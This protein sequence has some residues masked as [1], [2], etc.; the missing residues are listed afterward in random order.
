MLFSFFI[1]IITCCDLSQALILFEEKNNIQV[2]ERTWKVVVDINY[3]SVQ[4]DLISISNFFAKFNTTLAIF[5]TELEFTN[6]KA[7]FM[8]KQLVEEYTITYENYL[9]YKNE[10]INFKNLIP[11]YRQKRGLINIGG[12]ILN[13]LFGVMDDDDRLDVENKIADLTDKTSQLITDNKRELT[14]VRNINDLTKNNT[15]NINKII[16]H[17]ASYDQVLQLALGK[18]FSNINSTVTEIENYIQIT[19]VLKNLASNIEQA[20]RKITRLRA[21]LSMLFIGQVT[22]DLI[23]EDQFYKILLEVDRNINNTYKLPFAVHFNQI[24]N[25]YSIVK[26]H[27]IVRDNKIFVILEIPMI[28]NTN[29]NFKLMEVNSLP[30]YHPELDHFIAE[31]LDYKYIAVDNNTLRYFYITMYELQTCLSI[32]NGNLICPEKTIFHN[33]TD[34]GDC[35]FRSF[36]SKTAAENCKTKILTNTQ[37]VFLLSNNNDVYF[38]TSNRRIAISV[39][40]TTWSH[41]E[42]KSTNYSVV[43]ERVG[44]LNSVNGCKI[45]TPQFEYE[46]EG[47]FESK[48]KVLIP[49]VALVDSDIHLKLINSS[50]ILQLNETLSLQPDLIKNTNDIEIDELMENYK[51]LQQKS[52]A[53]TRQLITNVGFITCIA[54]VGIVLFLI[55]LHLHNKLKLA[56]LTS[57]LQKVSGTK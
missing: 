20:T 4:A 32:S 26:D 6:K 55:I 15:D 14:I 17:M 23:P 51:D 50:T 9:S 21:G 33:F 5:K 13:K 45:I 47:D 27:T 44:K 38:S 43:I 3:E 39:L 37:N 18:S 10:V 16:K 56:V 54:L 19:S 36:I 31:K 30:I 40:C 29:E 57:Q 42:L 1:I 24:F 12:T 7:S 52:K 22:P 2:R 35:I 25:F 53:E 28:E 46:V 8:D 34:P 11:N 49:S 48:F 41:N